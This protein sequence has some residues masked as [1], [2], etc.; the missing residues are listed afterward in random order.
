MVVVSNVSFKSFVVS[1]VFAESRKAA[2]FNGY[3]I[4]KTRAECSKRVSTLFVAVAIVDVT[5]IAVAVNVTAVVVALVI[6]TAV[7]FTN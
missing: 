2:V 4:S 1:I 3:K 5:A 7:I 6:P